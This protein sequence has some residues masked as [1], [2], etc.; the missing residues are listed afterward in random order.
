MSLLMEA[1]K[2]AELAKKK[3]LS[4]QD[5][6]N[7]DSVIS[8]AN[9]EERAD[10]QD[11]SSSVEIEKNVLDVSSELEVNED[12][13]ELELE[14]ML[15]D[16]HDDI[17]S[18]K[19]LD[20]SNETIKS[21]IIK[22]EGLQLLD[23]DV[24]SV[25]DEF[26]PIEAQ[27]RDI[28]EKNTDTD[29]FE[30]L[31][32]SNDSL[33][34][35]SNE[36]NTM[37]YPYPDQE[38]QKR[39]QDVG[40]TQQDLTVTPSDDVSGIESILEFSPVV[41]DNNLANDNELTPGMKEKLEEIKARDRL[42]SSANKDIENTNKE[43][44]EAVD[45]EKQQEEKHKEEKYKEEKYKEENDKKR[46]KAKGDPFTAEI[47]SAST[48]S[49]S[50][51]RTTNRFKN[52]R[53]IVNASIMSVIVIGAVVAY[54][55]LE[56]QL[57]SF[58]TEIVQPVSLNEDF[59]TGL[60]N[61]SDGQ[62]D[63]SSIAENNDLSSVESS[64]KQLI[65]N[66]ARDLIHQALPVQVHKTPKV[67]VKVNSAAKSLRENLLQKSALKNTTQ[68]GSSSNKNTVV[69]ALVSESGIQKKK[70]VKTNSIAKKISNNKNSVN[71]KKSVTISRSNT[72]DKTYQLLLEAYNDLN[73]GK[74]NAASEKYERVLQQSEE[75]RD[76]LLGLAAISVR[77]NNI[78]SAQDYYSRLLRKNKH[79]S[80]ALAG[81]VD[82]VGKMDPLAA[83]SELKTLLSRESGA[84]YLH[85]ALGNVYVTQQRWADAEASYFIASNIDKGSADY[86][87]N[88]AV[89]LDMLGESNQ[90]AQYYKKALALSKDGRSLFDPQ[91]VTDRLLSLQNS[92]GIK[93]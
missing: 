55:Y 92:S 14:K 16:N 17:D 89:S 1:L 22:T 5:S 57:Q 11:G 83:E 7:Q 12:E 46:N 42:Y 38:E 56:D 20:G 8:L 80:V 64:A 34:N 40:E 69:S 35:S 59:E 29:Q 63:E 62:S 93:K 91:V 10:L 76:A 23:D 90:A 19:I 70:I 37:D 32:L 21:E 9:N 87:Y 77:N 48:S 53:T 3:A 49:L 60:N 65:T 41:D 2:K 74:L 28:E 13:L 66:S 75:N 51:T 39:N 54:I 78:N 67:P 25:N 30:N 72:V 68:N 73:D 50:K 85:F 4:D 47:S 61:S 58:S 86:A 44:S 81:L 31:S 6:A 88:L 26:S 71:H 79:D 27:S 18:E 24:E 82:I 45:I 33:P 43:E 15:D 84:A 52:K 36:P